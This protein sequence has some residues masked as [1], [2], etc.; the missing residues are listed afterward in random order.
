MSKSKSPR[1]LLQIRCDNPV[2]CVQVLGKLGTPCL[3]EPATGDVTLHLAAGIYTILHW[4]ASSPVAR[5]PV[6]LDKD[7]RVFLTDQFNFLRD[8]TGTR[9]EYALALKLPDDSARFNVRSY[10]SAFVTAPPLFMPSRRESAHARFVDELFY[11]RRSGN[12]GPLFVARRVEANARN[13]PREPSPDWLMLRHGSLLSMGRRTNVQDVPEGIAAVEIAIHFVAGI[14]GF[15]LTGPGNSDAMAM[16]RTLPPLSNG[17]TGVFLLKTPDPSG[18]AIE[19][20]R[21]ARY[22]LHLYAD[23]RPDLTAA[24]AYHEE[25]VIERLGRAG[26][27]NP[28]LLDFARDPETINLLAALAAVL[29]YLRDEKADRALATQALNEVE[30]R[31]GRNGNSEVTLSDAAALAF[32]L[33]STARQ[34]GDVNKCE[35]SLDAPVFCETWKLLANVPYSTWD[36]A[37]LSSTI[38]TLQAA[39]YASAAG[40][41]FT[42]CAPMSQFTGRWLEGRISFDKSLSSAPAAFRELRDTVQGALQNSEGRVEQFCD[43]L[44]WEQRTPLERRILDFLVGSRQRKGSKPDEDE[45]EALERLSRCLG[46]PLP[47]V[48]HAVSQLAAKGSGTIEPPPRPVKA[49]AGSAKSVPVRELVYA[50]SAG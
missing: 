47:F 15:A 42:Y 4:V 21:T 11:D 38:G 25:A 30:S 2:T 50:R 24:R 43:D 19:D 39:H 23:D 34:G 17:R 36:S 8:E 6:N 28:Q 18:R 37:N 7:Q 40:V 20:W 32:L 12:R 13:A 41:W 46:L 35:I 5:H 27:V 26:G 33:R 3:R 44:K 9:S 22:S 16:I 45:K 10:H 49:P 29:L 31:L 1:L 14:S 48:A